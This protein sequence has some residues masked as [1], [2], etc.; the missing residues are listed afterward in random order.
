MNTFDIG[1]LSAFI[2]R[3]GSIGIS[4][5][6]HPITT[7]I[8]RYRPEISITTKS[9]KVALHLHKTLE[10]N[11]ISAKIKERYSKKENGAEQTSYQLCVSS[12][13][14]ITELIGIVGKRVIDTERMEALANF[15]HWHEK[16][17][18]QKTKKAKW[19]CEAKKLAFYEQ[20]SELN[21]LR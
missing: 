14:G 21:K 9:E 11:N 6:K 19:E 13:P 20:L 18:I 16:A 10:L 3:S 15:I 17:Q 4:V 8:L 2:D 12:L 5:T 1:Y 7:E